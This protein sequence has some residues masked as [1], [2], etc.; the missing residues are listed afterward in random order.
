MGDGD[1]IKPLKSGVYF[2]QQHSSVRVATPQVLKSNTWPWFQHWRAQFSIY[3]PV[4]RFHFCALDF[5]GKNPN[6]VFYRSGSAFHTIV[7]A[8]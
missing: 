6:C 1:V 8:P 2:T 7:P 3:D 4:C 5:L